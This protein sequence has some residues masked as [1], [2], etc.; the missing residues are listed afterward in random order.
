MA[1]YEV[2]PHGASALGYAVSTHSRQNII[3][4]CTNGPLRDVGI[5][6]RRSR[7]GHRV[8]GS[9]EGKISIVF[10]GLGF[11]DLVNMVVIV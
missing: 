7:S 11:N 5:R 4:I 9:A 1:Q 10:D 6:R 3:G 8:A 2:A